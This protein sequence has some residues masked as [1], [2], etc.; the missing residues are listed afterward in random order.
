MENLLEKEAEFHLFD[1]GL[2]Y[3]YLG[4]RESGNSDL[5]VEDAVNFMRVNMNESKALRWFLN[6]AF[7]RNHKTWDEMDEWIVKDLDKLLTRKAKLQNLDEEDIADI[8][9]Y[10]DLDRDDKNF[11]EFQIQFLNP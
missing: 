3:D 9:A 7:M 10:L 6:D 8:K 2:F 5:I 1:V 11:N 4:V